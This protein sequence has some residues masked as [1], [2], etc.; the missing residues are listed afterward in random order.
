M[1][2]RIFPMQRKRSYSINMRPDASHKK[3]E[4]LL[5]D[6]KAKMFLPEWYAFRDRVVARDKV[7]ARCDESNIKKLTAHHPHYPPLGTIDQ[8]NPW[9]FPFE[10]MVTLCHKCNS[11]E[12]WNMKANVPHFNIA[13]KLRFLSDEIVI[14]RKGIE[15][16]PVIYSPLITAKA[17]AWLMSS[18]KRM[19]TLITAF[20][21]SNS[22]VEQKQ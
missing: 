17:L 11:Y 9:D 3:W 14:L 13:Y 22:F 6:Y 15:C 12:E 1:E 20:Q 21:K 16:M 10:K 8:F 18:T 5:A 19:H 2:K 4:K 7:C